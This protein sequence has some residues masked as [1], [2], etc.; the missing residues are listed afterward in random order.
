MSGGNFNHSEWTLSNLADEVEEM[1]SDEGYPEEVALKLKEAAHNLRRSGEML[2]LADY[3]A[4]G[5]V[6]IESFLRRWA[7]EVSPPWEE[8]KQQ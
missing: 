6:G 8:N 4:C 1:L 2:K 5:D 7:E 3:L